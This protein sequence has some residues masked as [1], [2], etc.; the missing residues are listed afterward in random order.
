MWQED[1]KKRSA[2]DHSEMVDLSFSVDC[3]ELPYD[4]AYELSSEIIK[5]VPEIKND[6]RNAIQTLH[7]PM[8]GNGWVRADGEN[9]FLSKRAKL[10]LRVRKDHADK[11]RE[12]EGKKIKL[13]GNELNIGK[14]KI[15]SF[16]VVRDLFC[17]FVS[18]NEDLPEENFLEEVQTELRA[19]KVNI[20]KALCG[21][22]KRISFGSKTLYTRSLMIADL[23]K[24]EAVIL[25]E[26]GVGK[27]RLYGCGI[28]LPHKSID[29]VS[30]FKED[31]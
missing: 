6:N 31:D 30:N 2:V 23:T 20:N 11:I 17:R 12:I 3:K 9:I 29:A 7:G 21:Q 4:H 18:C 16:L 10:C 5:L 14:S 22:S 27:H 24:E 13:F 1:T 15:K 19:Y 8:S 26:E 28:F 25:Q